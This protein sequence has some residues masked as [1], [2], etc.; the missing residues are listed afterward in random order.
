MRF[1]CFGE[2]Y[3]ELR[4]G[5]ICHAE[6]PKTFWLP[7]LERRKNLQRGDAAKL[8]FEIECEKDDGNIIVQGERIFVI[9]S[10]IVQDKY[11]GILD[12]QPA[13]IEKG[14]KDVYL[15]FGAEV[16]FSSEHV[17]EIARPPD[18]Y[19]EWQL[20]LPPERSWPRK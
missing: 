11:I 17:I 18:E 2:N 13:C 3:W 4:N 9:V 7:E 12:S 19:I 5:E 1:A 14:N 16:C 15:C 10:E 20:G 6:N 8:I